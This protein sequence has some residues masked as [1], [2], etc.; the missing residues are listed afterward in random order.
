MIFLSSSPGKALIVKRSVNGT[1]V[2]ELLRKIDECL[3]N[4]KKVTVLPSNWQKVVELEDLKSQILFLQPQDGHVISDPKGKPLLGKMLL[5][6]NSSAQ[7]EATQG[8]ISI[9]K[10]ILRFCNIFTYTTKIMTLTYLMAI[11]WALTIIKCM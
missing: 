8:S 6:L 9:D 2:R 11:L 7:A 1:E 3:T 10:I 4:R 5:T